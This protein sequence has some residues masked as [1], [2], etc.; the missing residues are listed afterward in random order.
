MNLGEMF[1]LSIDEYEK[2]F[3]VKSFGQIQVGTVKVRQGLLT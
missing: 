3:L 1:F 2:L